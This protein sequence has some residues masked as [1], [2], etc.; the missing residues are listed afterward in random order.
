MTRHPTGYL[1]QIA[2]RSASVNPTAG[3]IAPPRV[4]SFLTQIPALP[5]TMP[6]SMPGEDRGFMT[7]PI[8]GLPAASAAP[9]EAVPPSEVRSAS[10]AHRSEMI[11]IQPDHSAAVESPPST[12]QHHGTVEPLPSRFE[13]MSSPQPAPVASRPSSTALPPPVALS[14]RSVVRLE[15][16]FR[17]AALEFPVQPASAADDESGPFEMRLPP[18][19]ARARMAAAPPQRQEVRVTIGR[20][21]VRVES[22]TPPAPVAVQRPTPS[23]PFASLALARRGWRSAF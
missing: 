17:A 23:D 11:E 12:P 9:I 21:E 10:S 18:S 15:P 5:L 19:L 13:P 7:D 1:Q 6:F 8:A 22:N 16:T 14:P 20:V 3:S 2:A 4:S